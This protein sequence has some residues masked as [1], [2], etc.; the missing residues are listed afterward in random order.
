[1]RWD[2][3]K[4]LKGRSDYV[5]YG[6]RK[7]ALDT[8]KTLRAENRTLKAGMRRAIRAM[9]TGDTLAILR[10]ALKGEKS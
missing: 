10:A 2:T 7:D 9:G 8:V 6:A 3:A 1:M 4:A 5:S